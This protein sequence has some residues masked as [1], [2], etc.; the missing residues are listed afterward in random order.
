MPYVPPR[1]ENDKLLRVALLIAAE[2]YTSTADENYASRLLAMRARE[3]V[4]AVNAL[5]AGQQPD[6][7]A[8]NICA[9]PHVEIAGWKAKHERVSTSV[10]QA[11]AEAAQF[12][13][14]LFDARG[15]VGDLAAL[16]SHEFLVN[17]PCKPNT[18]GYCDVHGLGRPCRN[19]K[20]RDLIRQLVDVTDT[21]EDR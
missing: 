21:K 12:R 6:G 1:P 17:D 10:A 2:R 16:L 15:I 18:D 20:A 4:V 11:K 5:P 3:L 9:D 13:S 19:E 14:Q 8:L 7:W